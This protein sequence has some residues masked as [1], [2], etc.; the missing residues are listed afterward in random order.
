VFF[1]L[2]HL[3]H[4]NVEYQWT[5]ASL[6]QA[7]NEL[8]A[9]CVNG[10]ALFGGGICDGDTNCPYG[11]SSIVDLWNSSTNIWT[12]ASLSEARS[13]LAA[14]SVNGVALFGGG[15]CGSNINCYSSGFSKVVDLWNSSTNSWTIS[16]LS[17]ARSYLAATSVNGVALFG[18][19]NGLDCNQSNCIFNHSSLFDL[20]NSST[21]TWTTA[22]LSEAREQLSA[23]SVNDLALFGGG[24]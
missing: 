22:S 4:S 13:Y 21:N 19:G 24:F 16:S 11:S 8:A 2:Y 1:L 10:V 18:G 5:T 7:R 15:I 23:T 9:T 6:S 14:T 12:T 20:W 3:V 17:L